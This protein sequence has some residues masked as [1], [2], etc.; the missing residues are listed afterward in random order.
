V[1]V[2]SG[3][4]VLGGE[5]VLARGLIVKRSLRCF[6]ASAFAFMCI[7]RYFIL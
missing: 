4:G 6:L 1:S 2:E 5:K 7:Y 3:V